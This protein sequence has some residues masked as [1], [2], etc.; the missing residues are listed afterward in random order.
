MNDEKRIRLA[1]ESAETIAVVGCSPN[2]LRPSNEIASYLIEQGYRV[3]P[4]N[5]GHRRV[6][7]VEC[8]RSLT[9]IPEE[10]RVDIVDVFR[11]SD[12]VAGVAEEAIA[13]RVPFVFLQLG[14]VDAA[15]ALRMEE[16]GIGVA[17]NRCILVDHRRLG[18]GPRPGSRNASREARVSSVSRKG[19][20]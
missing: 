16:N 6:L 19:T 12:S 9:D 10:I 14:V 5:P 18:I 7:G 3:V 2:P 15:A 8:Y 20:T 11:R 17:M 1:L 4:V 13:R